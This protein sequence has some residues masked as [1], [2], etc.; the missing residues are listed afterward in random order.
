MAQMKITDPSIIRANR[1]PYIYYGG[2]YA[3]GRAAFLR[4]LYPDLIWGAVASS[5]VTEARTDFSDY[6]LA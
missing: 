4:K 1:S 3:G 6:F 2:S 5:G